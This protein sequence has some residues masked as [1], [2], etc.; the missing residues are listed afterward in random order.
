M[1]RRM[2]VRCPTDSSSRAAS[3]VWWDDVRTMTG[4][5]DQGGCSFNSRA[6]RPSLSLWMASSGTIATAAPLSISEH[7]P[8]MFS[9]TVRAMPTVLKTFRASA[10][11]RFVGARSKIRSSRLATD[12]S[13]IVRTRERAFRPV[14]D[15]RPGEYA[16]EITERRAEGNPALTEPQLADGPLVLTAPLLD[17]RDGLPHLAH[18]LEV[19]EEHDRV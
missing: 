7:T 2:S 12:R 11:S 18:R 8:A 5:S 19:A 3:F 10:A 15:R 17:D 16:M 9:Q 4:K 1:G 6:R 13:S 14:V